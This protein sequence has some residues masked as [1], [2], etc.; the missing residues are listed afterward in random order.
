MTFYSSLNRTARVYNSHISSRET[1]LRELH[2]QRNVAVEGFPRDS[3]TL[4]GLTGQ[5]KS[6][7]EDLAHQTN[8]MTGP[9][10]STLLEAFQLPTNGAVEIRKRRF[11]EFVGLVVD[12]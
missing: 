1:P 5:I 7:I 2:D 12:A 6:H 9:A 3:S 8:I 4:M 10:I 11:R